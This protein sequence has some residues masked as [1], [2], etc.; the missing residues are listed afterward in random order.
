MTT[1][2]LILTIVS[3]AIV[4]STAHAQTELLTLQHAESIAMQN[5][6]AVN[7]YLASA[8]AFQNQ[9]IA[10]NSLP[11][12]KLRLG[13]F[14]V[15][16]DDFDLKKN[17]TT[18]L[19][20]GIQQQ[21]PRGDTLEI[22]AEQNKLHASAA[23]ARSGDTQR[24]LLRD[25]RNTYLN[26]YYETQAASI[27]DE[28][29]TLFVKLADI[30]EDRYAT[31]RANQQDVIRAEL[32]LSR[33]ASR[34]TKILNKQDQYRAELSI[35]LGDAAQ[36]KI[37]YRFPTLSTLPSHNIDALI[38]QH[39]MI[40][41]QRN[42]VDAMRKMTEIA[43][44]DYSPGFHAFIEY[45]KRF[46]EDPDGSRRDDLAAAMVTMDIP[47]FTHNRQKKN[48]AANNERVNAA[49]YRLDD[50]LRKLKQS[51]EKN[52]SMYKRSNEL[53]QIFN[54]ALLKKAK[55]NSNASLNSYQ[56]GV[57][58]FTTLMRAQITELDTRLD[59]LRVKV[60]KAIAQANLLYITGE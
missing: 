13:M 36:H 43:K 18:Q 58:E 35:W 37:D 60:D 25:L 59:A 3:L 42:E 34:H 33:L 56:S 6:P 20:L 14:N 41:A 39:P 5:D 10:S 32:E 40:L 24:K 21:F 7:N 8:R 16:L 27:I 1:A 28:T 50:A 44:Q 2:P 31:G 26:L 4:L 38:N 47:L 22:R 11:D 55:N 17:P 9:A 57:T 12:P 46:G 45:R 29:R 30:T 19:R 51:Y 54:N 53:E 48:V 52:K 49:R 15:P 23:T